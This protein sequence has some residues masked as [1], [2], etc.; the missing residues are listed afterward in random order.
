[1]GRASFS[2]ERGNLTRWRQRFLP[3]ANEIVAS[4]RW[5][6]DLST[7]RHDDRCKKPHATYA[8]AVRRVLVLLIALLALASCASPGYD[9]GR[10]RSELRRAG[11]TD[12]QARC[13]T[14]GMEKAFD[15]R[16]LSIYSDPNAQE[17]ATTR[18]LV[19]KCGL[20]LPPQ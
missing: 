11:L 10:I 15:P 12:A 8:P 1:M 19:A 20:K 13:V 3:D 6:L 14:D 4:R 7:Q 16:E 2:E 17:L 9:P 5:N 18:G